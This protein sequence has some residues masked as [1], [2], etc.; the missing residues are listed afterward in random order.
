MSESIEFE[1]IEETIDMSV[2]EGLPV[3]VSYTQAPSIVKIYKAGEILSGHRIVF[4]TNSKAYYADKEDLESCKLAIGM[5]KNAAI[6]DADVEVVEIGEI[7]NPEWDLTPES[8][9]FLDTLGQITTT[10][11]A[12]DNLLSVGKSLT[13]EK[14]FVNIGFPLIRV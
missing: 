2:T 13:D 12:G 9:Y 5:T 11:P 6:I 10:P 4:I 7:V 14:F 3:T 8:V 1:V